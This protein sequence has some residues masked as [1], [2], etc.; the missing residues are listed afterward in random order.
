MIGNSDTQ[1][2]T[3]LKT[4]RLSASISVNMRCHN[5]RFTTS[6][7]PYASCEWIKD[8]NRRI[9]SFVMTNKQGRPTISGILRHRLIVTTSTEKKFVTQERRKLSEFLNK[10]N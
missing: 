8:T 9:A 4:L 1:W 2:I 6:F 10:S 7:Y 5:P 3:E